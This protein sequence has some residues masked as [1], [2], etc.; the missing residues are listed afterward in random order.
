VD[1][2]ENEYNIGKAAFYK[3]KPT[4]LSN[5]YS[6]L[7]NTA[8]PPCHVEAQ[9]TSSTRIAHINKIRQG[10]LNGSIPSAVA[11]SGITTNLGTKKD[12]TK[13]AY[14]P[15]NNHSSQI[16]QLLDGTRTPASNICLLHRNIIPNIP[17]N[18]LISTAEFAEAGYITVFDDKE[19]NVYNAS[20][21]KVIVTRQA[22]LRGWL[23][24]DANLY[25]IPLVPIVLNNNTNTVLVCKPPT[26]FLP[27][28]LRPTKTIHNVYELKMQPELVWYLHMVA[29]FPMK[30]TWLGAIKNNQFASWPGL[31][32]KAVA[33]HYPESKETIKGHGQKGWSGL[34]STKT[35][36]PTIEPPAAPN[37][38]NEQAHPSPKRYDVFIKVFSAEE[39]GNT[40]TFANQT[41]QFPKK[42]SKGNQY[43][44][45]LAHPD[46]NRI[47]Q[48][49]MKNGTS[50]KMIQ[51]YQCLI[52][53]LKSAGITPKHH[54]LVNKCS[55]EFKATIKKNNMMYQLVPRHDHCQNLAK[56]AIQ[57]FKAHLI[58]ILCGAKTEFPLHL[59]DRLLPQAEH[60]STC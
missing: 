18:L 53:Q 11:D 34:C 60:T 50:G 8:P 30:P 54:I 24:K 4:L 49:P 40:T 59:W 23:D 1:T 33:K 15:T 48:E 43:I 37:S 13:Q 9:V 17:T 58:S 21:M 42:S 57:T 26:K 56:K 6:I 52:N 12:K 35:K 14:I 44:M 28:H 29:G 22:I 25:R 27:D 5:Y 3:I 51:S 10:V 45:V 2:N 7:S 36:E 20:N 32:V 41:G 16:F 38:D 39:E 46:S 19:V 31:T 47:L 55:E